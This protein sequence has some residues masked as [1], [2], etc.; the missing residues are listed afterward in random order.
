MKVNQWLDATCARR[1][2][3]FLQID[4]SA[5][6]TESNHQTA[7]KNRRWFVLGSKTLPPTSLHSTILQGYNMIKLSSY[8]LHSTQAKQQLID[9]LLLLPIA[10][11]ADLLVLPIAC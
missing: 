4:S 3:C 8:S 10:S 7:A 6:L 9:D 5:E 11:I 2:L 1:F